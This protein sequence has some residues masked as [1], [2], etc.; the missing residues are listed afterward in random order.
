V[1][2][3]R[4][5]HPPEGLRRSPLRCAGPPRRLRPRVLPARMGHPAPPGMTRMTVRR[6]DRRCRPRAAT[7]RHALSTPMHESV[8]RRT[9]VGP[10]RGSGASQV[11][12]TN[13]GH[14]RRGGPGPGT[15]PHS[16]RDTNERTVDARRSVQQHR[17]GVSAAIV[18]SGD[19]PEGRRPSRPG[20][21]GRTRCGG[22][23]AG[24]CSSSSSPPIPAHACPECEGHRRDERQD[25]GEA[26]QVR[27]HRLLRLEVG[28]LSFRR[29]GGLRGKI[30][31][32][33]SPSRGGFA[34]DGLRAK[35]VRPHAQGTYVR[36]RVTWPGSTKQVRIQSCAAAHRQNGGSAGLDDR[37]QVR[38]QVDRRRGRGRG[39]RR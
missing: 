10:G 15:T 20:W 2:A 25:P 34:L 39:G 8:G 22:T 27:L 13:A 32:F 35:D 1:A 5:M 23:E 33:A 24:R 37:R 19:P 17:C 4:T 31:G 9:S 18:T 26:R 3:R 38:G 6:Q 21:S 36:V 16:P 7:L 14:V 12:G 11:S 30:P 29:P 28:A